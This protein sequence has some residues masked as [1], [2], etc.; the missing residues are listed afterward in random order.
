ML[1]AHIEFNPQYV[2]SYWQLAAVYGLSLGRMDEAIR[3]YV[4][5]VAI[6]PSI[7][8]YADLVRFHLDLSDAEGAGRWLEELHR[9]YP[10][11]HHALASRYLLQRHRGAVEEALETAK[12]LEIH[13]E[14]LPGYD[15]MGDFAWLRQLQS[16]DADAALTAYARLYPELTADPA[17][18]NTNNYAAAA[19]LSLLH[20]QAGDQVKGTQL[21][22][23]SLAAM[24]TMPVVGTAGH[25]FTDAMAHAIAGDAEQ[26]MTALQRDLDTGFR[27]DWWLMRVEP[28]FEPLWG[29]PEFQSLMAEV[30]ADMATQLAQ[31]RE[32]EERGELVLTPELPAPGNRAS[33]P[34]P[35]DLQ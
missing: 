9:A 10:D 4:R 29:L 33:G 28:V 19:S 26:A 5:A 20:L 2:N 17:A 31:L 6:D 13:A 1:R 12:L 3:W 15:L 27:V 30:E 24:E 23:D 11:G 35:R 8:M 7:F 18:V 16:A 25:G 21:L 22:R 14:R 34:S 32:M